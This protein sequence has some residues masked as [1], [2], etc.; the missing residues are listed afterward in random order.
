MNSDF[1]SNNGVT[2]HPTKD[3]YLESEV[4]GEKA[5]YV[6]EIVNGRIDNTS[7]DFSAGWMQVPDQLRDKSVAW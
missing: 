4:Y 1:S 6:I 7:P 3:C 2:V 5:Y